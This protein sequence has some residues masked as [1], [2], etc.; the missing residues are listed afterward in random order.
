MSMEQASIAQHCKS[1][2]LASIAGQ[3]ASLAEEAGRQNHSHLHYLEALLQGEVEDRERRS[4]E[5][6][7]KD[8]HLPRMKTLEEFDFTQSPH[9][10]ASR[11]R[12]L[13][14]GS[15]AA[16]ATQ[17]GLADRSSIYRHAHALGLFS[18]RQ[19]NI[20]AALEK[21]IERAEGVEVT[22]SAVVAAIQAYSKI[23]AAG[24]WVDRTETVSLN[25]LFDRM[26]AQELERYAQDGTLPTW[27]PAVAASVT[28][29][30]S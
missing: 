21:I 3:F 25:Q 2:R 22:A 13:A 14:W 16:I 8:A 1:L 18:K 15:P 28:E 5:L 20:R 19:K 9:I 26:T 23:N 6:R 17:Y 11:I 12:A 7:L 24:E 30:N 27:F 10:P 4:I 29:E